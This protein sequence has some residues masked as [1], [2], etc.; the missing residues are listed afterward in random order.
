M[1]NARNTQF[2][3]GRLKVRVVTPERILLEVDATSVVLPG[4]S[5]VL[6]VLPG[7][8]PLLTAIGAG[9]L[10]VTGV[11]GGADGGAGSGAGD[12]R[13]IVARGFAEVLPDRVTVLVECGERPEAVD[14]PAA[15]RQ[16]AD[17]QKQVADAGQDPE[18]YRAARLVVLE[19]EAK[20]GRA[21]Q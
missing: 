17:G 14:R 6:E 4:E 16:L 1:A 10:L 21:G 15:E 19:A 20:L 5:G 3:G 9:E 12:G 11:S 7:A 18:R 13:L 2:E 8:A